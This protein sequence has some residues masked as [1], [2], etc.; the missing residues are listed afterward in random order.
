MLVG[1]QPLRSRAA[2]EL[3]SAAAEAA[4]AT[5][6]A[7]WQ[8]ADRRLAQQAQQG[9][10]WHDCARH[11]CPRCRPCCSCRRRCRCPAVDASA[12]RE[13]RWAPLLPLPLL[14]PL[15][16]LPLLLAA[17]VQL[18]PGHEAAGPHPRQLAL[19]SHC[20][21]EEAPSRCLQMPAC[22]AVLPACAGPPMALKPRPCR[23]PLPLLLL[24]LARRLWVLTAVPQPLLGSVLPALAALP[25][26]AALPPRLRLLLECWQRRRPGVSH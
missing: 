9:V 19:L 12:G 16:W 2:A 22:P 7:A 13:E 3:A 10:L 21:W 18:R 6:E 1:R 23:P 8:L 17:A 26:A 11:R 25:A 24:P 4:A 14:P 20:Q 5:A 15:P